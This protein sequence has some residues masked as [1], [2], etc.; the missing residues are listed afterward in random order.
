MLSEHACGE[1]P[2]LYRRSTEACAHNLAA[3]L[4]AHVFVVF[5]ARS[6][7]TGLKHPKAFSAVRSLDQGLR[8]EVFW[9][10]FFGIIPVTFVADRAKC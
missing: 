10:R 1:R 5:T 2:K 7:P 3:S 9:R 6:S 8:A 4:F